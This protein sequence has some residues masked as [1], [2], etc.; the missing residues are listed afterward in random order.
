MQL[1][2]SNNIIT[3]NL[4]GKPIQCVVR[5]SQGTG[6]PISGEYTVRPPTSDPIFGRT[7][8]VILSKSA[9]SRAVDPLKE[10][11]LFTPG[12]VS[13][14]YIKTPSGAPQAGVQMLI[15]SDKPIAG[16]NCLIVTLG[17]ADLMSGLDA[18]GGATLTVP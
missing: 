2:F 7:A 11:K 3:G 15:L 9:V 13:W 14:D 5:M 16:R 18:S 17:F 12:R 4:G 1:K 10:A 8:L 6:L